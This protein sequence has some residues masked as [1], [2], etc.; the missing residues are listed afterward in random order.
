MEHTSGSA[1]IG[2]SIFSLTS[3]HILGVE[4]ENEAN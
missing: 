3:S 2:Y 4:T 1:F